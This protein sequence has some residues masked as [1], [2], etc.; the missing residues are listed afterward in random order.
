MW[1]LSDEIKEFQNLG[2]YEGGAHPKL[3][4]FKSATD[5]KDKTKIISLSE[6]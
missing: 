3:I 4:S 2:R 6:K 1:S 5:A